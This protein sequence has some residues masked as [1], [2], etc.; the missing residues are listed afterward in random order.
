MVGHWS[1][2][3][4]FG[5]IDKFSIDKFRNY[6]LRIRS[7]YSLRIIANNMFAPTIGGRRR[8]TR[9]R[10]RCLRRH[11]PRRRI[12]SAKF[13]FGFVKCKSIQMCSVYNIQHRI[14]MFEVYKCARYKY[15]TSN[16]LSAYGH[17]QL[18]R[19]LSCL[20]GGHTLYDRLRHGFWGN[21]LRKST[22]STLEY[23]AV[24]WTG[25]PQSLKLSLFHLSMPIRWSHTD[26][27]RVPF[28]HLNT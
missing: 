25:H 8:R 2:A 1:S 6:S 28:Q 24:I 10:F 26:C 7:N 23:L 4:P 9:R 22:L 12:R 5:S 18:L 17:A 21:G 13:G 11:R 19:N 14:L 27:A 3:R 16:S 20:S 15:S